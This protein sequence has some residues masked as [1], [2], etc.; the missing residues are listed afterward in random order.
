MDESLHETVT[1]KL[2]A[3]RSTA[4]LPGNPGRPTPEARKGPSEPHSR[5]NGMGRVVPVSREVQRLTE[6]DKA[7][8]GKYA[9]VTDSDTGQ[10]Y[11]LRIYTVT[12]RRD[13]KVR[14]EMRNDARTFYRQ[15]HELR[16]VGGEHV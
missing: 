10:E 14:A 6:A 8:I 7:L 12:V 3:L 13:G 5:T 4:D 11:R 2:D 15:P 1:R 16:N 9:D